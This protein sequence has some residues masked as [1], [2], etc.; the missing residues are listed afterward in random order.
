[1]DT[2]DMIRDIL[3]PNFK[4]IILNG[5]KKYEN[6]F[7]LILQFQKHSLLLDKRHKLPQ[8]HT[9]LHSAY[10]VI[11]KNN[12]NNSNSLGNLNQR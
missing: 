8:I 11:K 5:L 9:N 2:D 4:T 7:F 10:S 3:G 12:S 1:M 6:N